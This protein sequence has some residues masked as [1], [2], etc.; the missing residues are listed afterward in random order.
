MRHYIVIYVRLPPSPLS[1]PGL[2]VP[3]QYLT[4]FQAEKI[5]ETRLGGSSGLRLTQ[6]KARTSIVAAEVATRTGSIWQVWTVLQICKDGRVGSWE[7]P[8][9]RVYETPR[10]DVTESAI[11]DF[12]SSTNRETSFVC[13]RKNDGC[14]IFSY[15]RISLK[16]AAVW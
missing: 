2:R 1:S 13:N 7:M 6:V 15:P 11:S 3:P 10:C 5:T 9:R 16:Y 14:T 4:L 8:M 12:S